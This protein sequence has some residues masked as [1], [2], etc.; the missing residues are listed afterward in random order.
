M[1]AA[2]VRTSGRRDNLPVFPQ[3]AGNKG[4]WG[5]FSKPLAFRYWSRLLFELV[6]HGELLLFAALLFK[7]EQKAFP[8]RI[9]VFDLEVHYG[10]NPSESVSKDPEQSAIA[11]A[12]VRGLSIALRSVWTS[13][14]TNAGVLPSV[15]ENLSILT[16]WAGFMARTPFSVSQENSIRIAAMCCLTLAARPGD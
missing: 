15:R 10:A 11:E 5:S 9:I 8:G 6:V 2:S 16:S 12:G 4:D 7:A 3:A 13:P 14:S 1:S